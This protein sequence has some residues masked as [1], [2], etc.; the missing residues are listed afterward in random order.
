MNVFRLVTT[1]FAVG[2]EKAGGLVARCPD[3]QVRFRTGVGDLDW[4]QQP[5]GPGGSAH[6]PV[7]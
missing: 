1:V 3:E 2:I 4:G 7:N 6:A 5:L